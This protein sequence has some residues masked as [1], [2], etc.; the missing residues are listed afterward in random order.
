MKAADAT[1]LPKPVK[2]GL[3]TKN[4]VARSPDDLLKWIKH[5][6]PRASY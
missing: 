4:K 6:K 5:L 1:N 3:R 2:V